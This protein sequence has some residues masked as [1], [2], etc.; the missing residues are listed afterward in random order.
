MN[1]RFTTG[2]LVAFLVLTSGAKADPA[3]AQ[4][5][6]ENGGK[7]VSPRQDRPG[8]TV[9]DAVAQ[10]AAVTEDV[11]KIATS[12]E[13]VA[14]PPIEPAAA[15]AD[16]KPV[17]AAE[18]A[19]GPVPA[20]VADLPAPIAP[21]AKKQAAR[22]KAAD[23][24]VADKKVADKAG[25]K[26]ARRERLAAV[27]SKQI[28]V[29]P[30]GNSE[31]GT[32]AWYGGRYIGRRTSSGERLDTTHPTCAHRSL[33]L[34][35]LARVTNLQNGRSVVVRVTDRGPLS[36]SLLIDMSPR[37]AEAL[38]MKSAGLARVKVE[39]VVAVADDSK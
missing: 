32:A 13:I 18:A 22:E 2:F 12:T 26:A 36:E 25:T 30:V 5:A 37:A 38:A 10:I 14:A 8:D 3:G 17:A 23:K 9:A 28:A 4:P 35:S 29:R 15:M 16:E 20:P 27:E 6:A 1:L 21:T 19:P 33:P 31:V 7:T 11:A 39:Q 34:N 24:K